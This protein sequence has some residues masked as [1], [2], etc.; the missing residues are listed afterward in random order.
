MALAASLV[1]PN[2]DAEVLLVRVSDEFD[3][4]DISTFLDHYLRGPEIFD[5]TIVAIGGVKLKAKSFVL[6]AVVPG[7]VIR[8]RRRR[9]ASRP[10]SSSPSG[11]RDG[12]TEGLPAKRCGQR[13]VTGVG[14]WRPRGTREV[15]AP[16]LRRAPPP[17]AVYFAASARP[18][19]SPTALVNEA[20]LRARRP[21]ARRLAESR[22]FLRSR[23]A[24]DAAHPGRSRESDPA[25]EAL[26]RRRPRV[27]LDLIPSSTADPPDCDLLAARSGPR[28]SWHRSMPSRP[29]SWTSILRRADGDRGGQR[30]RPF[31]DP[32]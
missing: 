30:A 8:Y 26:R 15:A 29:G 3:G 18:H 25:R 12:N 17:A 19:P 27:A 23:G 7:S 32:P 13:L 14:S 24:D 10:T 28:R 31:R 1:E 9:H 16:R 21:A 20:Y 11:P 22:A 5:R 2:A 4:S 6:P